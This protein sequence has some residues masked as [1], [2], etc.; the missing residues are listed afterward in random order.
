MS[1]AVLPQLEAQFAAS[2]LIVI[3]GQVDAGV[4]CLFIVVDVGKA[5]TLV[6][7][8]EHAHDVAGVDVNL[9]VE[10]HLAGY[11]HCVLKQ[12]A[13]NVPCPVWFWFLNSQVQVERLADAVLVGQ[14]DNL[15]VST[16]V[17][18]LV[19]GACDANHVL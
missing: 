17:Q 14:I 16:H 8:V 12:L 5:V 3:D 19:D 11:V 4:A 13:R 15:I 7:V 1:G 9:V 2:C 6:F 18:T 10:I